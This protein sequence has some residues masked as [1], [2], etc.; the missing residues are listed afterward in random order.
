MTYDSDAASG[1]GVFDSGTNY[2]IPA[3]SAC[4]SDERQYPAGAFRRI[5][6]NLFH[7]FGQGPAGGIEPS[8]ANS[9]S[10][11]AG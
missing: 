6:G 5:T 10:V 4:P 9:W 8:Q 7:L 3:L 1:A 11:L 2:W